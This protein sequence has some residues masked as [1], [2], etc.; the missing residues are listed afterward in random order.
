MSKIEKEVKILNV[1]VESTRKK[2]DDIGANFKNKKDQKIY[3]YDL[4]G[5]NFRF[6]E[7]IFFLESDNPLTRNTALK[8]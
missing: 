7:T 1:D 6:N 8:N 3:T 4:I 2:L 5:I